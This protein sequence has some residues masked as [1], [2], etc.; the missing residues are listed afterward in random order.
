M[1]DDGLK[2]RFSMSPEESARILSEHEDAARRFRTAMSPEDRERLPYYR[3]L[4]DALSVSDTALD[5]LLSVRREQ[6][7][8]MLLLAALHYTALLGNPTLGP[9]YANA[10]S[11]TGTP[12]QDFATAVVS[13]LEQ[14]PDVIQRQLH[15]STQTNEVGRSGI[16]IAVL[17]E[18][19]RRGVE[20]INLVDVGMSAGLNLYPDHYRVVQKDDGS[21]DALICEDLT[22][23]NVEGPLPLIEQRIGI[24]PSPLDVVVDDDALWLRACLW[25]E[26]TRRTRRLQALIP[27]V[28]NWERIL[29]LR[30]TALEMIDEAIVEAGNGAPTLVFHSWVAAY[31]SLEE[32]Q[33]W[34]ARMLKI[35]RS[36][37]VY[38]FYLEWPQAIP[39]LQ[40]P[41]ASTTSPQLGGSQI[42]LTS[43]GGEPQP[44]GWCHAHGH[45]LSFE[46]VSDKATPLA[47]S[48]GIEDAT[49]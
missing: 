28:R 19:R 39:G 36:K 29:R 47:L 43:P 10:A 41:P 40:P 11:G 18:L 13:F 26:D 21:V 12:P 17:R 5:L 9:L 42:V 35:T 6:Q 7:N 48:L 16:V 3:H 32:Q 22:A 25:P 2:H 33:A 46:P 20:K 23:F 49:D 24:D 45:W 30:G 1:N 31:F 37:P 8:P 15:R 27:E 38:W 44:W 34:R 14:S 4:V